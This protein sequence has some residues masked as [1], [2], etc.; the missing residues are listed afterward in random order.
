MTI[1]S[2]Y[3][4]RDLNNNVNDE[5]PEYLELVLLM[6][7][8][9]MGREKHANRINKLLADLVEGAYLLEALSRKLNCRVVIRDREPI[10]AECEQGR[11]VDL[12]DLPALL[13]GDAEIR[14]YRINFQLMDL[15]E[16]PPLGI[17]L[18]D[19]RHSL[20]SEYYERLFYQ[21]LISSKKSRKTLELLERL[22]TDRFV[23]ERALMEVAG[24]PRKVEHYSEH[25]NILRS[26][27]EVGKALESGR[28]DLALLKLLELGNTY[29]YHIEKHDVRLAQ[30]LR[31]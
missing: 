29:A 7:G 11:K 27:N 14:L 28:A 20:I 18:M 26:L 12:K 16:A 9:L 5:T 3:P 6:K 1:A 17:E 19:Y 4:S 24:Y 15:R 8:R 21:L 13:N 10:Y 25:V 30:C 2:E 31:S 23:I 22:L